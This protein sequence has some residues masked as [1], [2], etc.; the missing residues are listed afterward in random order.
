LEKFKVAVVIPAYNEEKTLKNIVTKIKRFAKPIIVD[1]GSSDKTRL[2]ISKLGIDIISNGKNMGYE[3]SIVKGI[4]YAKKKKF[5]FIVTF[6]ADGQHKIKDLKRIIKI[7][8]K[9]KYCCVSGVRKNLQRF[10]EYIFSFISR[11]IYNIKDPLCGLKGYR[12][13]C[14]K[15]FEFNYKN[16]IC[17]ELIFSLRRK[18]KPIKQIL[19]S[20]NLRKN[21]PR[22]GGIFTSNIKILLSAIIIYKNF[23]LY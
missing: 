12:S 5:R 14:L 15:F 16:S 17:T 3:Y 18:K 1:D 2:I 8:K 4:K 11:K 6:D 21:N 19:I 9:N 10:S 23:I 13:N 7:L 22:F 20:T